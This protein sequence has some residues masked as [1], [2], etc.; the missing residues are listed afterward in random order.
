MRNESFGRGDFLLVDD[1]IFFLGKSG[2]RRR[3]RTPS[4]QSASSPATALRDRF[5]RLRSR[6]RHRQLV[7]AG[8]TIDATVEVVAAAIAHADAHQ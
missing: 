4:P 5:H 6:L 8:F 3:A 2:K 1:R 7:H